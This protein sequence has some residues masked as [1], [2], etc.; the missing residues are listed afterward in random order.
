M[1]YAPD[2]KT[3]VLVQAAQ[4]GDEQARNALYE[5]HWRKVLSVVRLRMGGL[6]R[7]RMES[8]DIMQSVMIE[9]MGSLGRFKY[10]SEGAFVHWLSK[11]VENKLKDKVDYLKAQKRNVDLDEPGG[12][13]E[14]NVADTKLATPSANMRKVELV[15]QLEQ[16]LKH[17]DEEDRELIIMSKLEELSYAEIAAATG[18]TSEAV[19]K[20]IARALT[21]LSSCVSRESY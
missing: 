13:F 14:D 4:L 8:R 2:D 7:S 20:A 5:K 15:E 12:F 18:R 6:L 1:S 17:L 19:R 11:M 16:A 9:S 3:L 21:S 10:E